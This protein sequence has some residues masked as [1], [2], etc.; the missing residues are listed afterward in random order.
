STVAAKLHCKRENIV[1]IENGL[2]GKQFKRYQLYCGYLGI[3]LQELFTNAMQERRTRPPRL[4]TDELLA[5]VNEVY[6]KM[7][8]VTKLVLPRQI[9]EE[10]GVSLRTLSGRKAVRERLQEISAANIWSPE[11]LLN[12]VNTAY[13]KLSKGNKRILRRDIAHEI[14]VS[15]DTLKQYES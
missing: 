7:S 13:A 6:A 3:T 1:Q 14:G 11:K 15:L 12:E 9:A 4:S 8:K 2:S 5:R 10:I